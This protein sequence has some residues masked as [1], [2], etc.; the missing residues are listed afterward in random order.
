MIA[1][2]Q[3]WLDSPAG[4][5]GWLIQGDETRGQSAKRFDGRTSETQD[6]VPP[7]LSIVYQPAFAGDY[8]DDSKVNALDYTVWRNHLGEAIHLPNE[9]TTFGV[10]NEAD[11]GVWKSN[12]G[13][14][15]GPGAGG[16]A[17]VPEPASDWL[18]V[19]GAMMALALGRWS[20]GDRIS[21]TSFC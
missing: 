18:A 15:E 2:V 20:G 17:T 7:T 10:V 16:V 8:N 4:N 6:D 9:T 12:F 14:V 21:G 5:F 13:K 11:F 19:G 1:D 3:T